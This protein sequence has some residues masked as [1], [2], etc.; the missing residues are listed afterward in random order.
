VAQL[1]VAVANEAVVKRV[2]YFKEMSQNVEYFNRRGVTKRSC[3]CTSMF[4]FDNFSISLTLLP[5]QNTDR[6]SIL[7]SCNF[8]FSY[9]FASSFHVSVTGDAPLTSHHPCQPVTV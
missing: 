9:S 8:Y 7:P 6:K 5:V 1:N 4:H 3:G 2:N